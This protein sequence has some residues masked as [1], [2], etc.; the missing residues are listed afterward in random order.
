MEAVSSF[1]QAAFGNWGSSSSLS[2]ESVIPG[3]LRIYLKP[4]NLQHKFPVSKSAKTL[5][6][7]REKGRCLFKISCSQ[8][9]QQVPQLQA[10][11]IDE[12]Y[13]TLAERLFPTAAVA[14]NRNRKYIVGLVAPPGAGK[15][16]L[17][18]E[19]VRR[20]NKLWHQR[21]LSFDDQMEPPE[22]AVV[23]PMDGFHLY[24]HQLD[25]MENP[26][27]AHARRGAP[28]TFDP[29]RLMK[30]LENL[31]NHGSAYAPSFCHHVGDPMEN[32]VYVGLQHKVVIVEGNYLL[33][34]EGMWKE[35][36]SMFDEKWFIDIEIEKAMQRVLKRH[37]KTGQ[38][39]DVAKFRVDYNDRPNAQLIINSKANADLIIS[40]I[41][42]PN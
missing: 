1:S 38:P 6:V 20:V 27:E 15:S 34:G 31:K 29:A 7:Q 2:A 3:K 5:L 4:R 37:I 22:V 41:D 39:P 14:S 12:I 23:L 16:T 18:H 8:Q 26:E 28:W 40:S 13:D 9:L 19:V 17:A 11:S 25:A 33:L 35:L 32:E 30:C 24:R 21:G 36:S 10:S 42:F